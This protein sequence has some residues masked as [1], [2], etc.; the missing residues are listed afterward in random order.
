MR[1]L[2]TLLIIVTIMALPMHGLAQDIDSCKGDLTACE[3]LL[4]E[5]IGC[6]ECEACPPCEDGAW[7]LLLKDRTLQLGV[8]TTLVFIIGG[9]VGIFIPPPGG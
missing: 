4:D 7:K 3:Q 8:A 1:K 6:P 2:I 5:C 9:I